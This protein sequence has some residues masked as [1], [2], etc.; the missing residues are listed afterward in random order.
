MSYILFNHLEVQ[1]K[2]NHIKVQLDSLLSV[3]TNKHTNFKT[4]F[5]VIAAPLSTAFKCIGRIT[6]EAGCGVYERYFVKTRQTVIRQD[7]YWHYF[8]LDILFL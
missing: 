6:S 5:F 8:S 2:Y 4:L 1:Q 7:L 3:S